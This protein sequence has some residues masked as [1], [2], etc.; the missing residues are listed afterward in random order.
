MPKGDCPT[1]FLLAGPQGI[2][3]RS[4]VLETVILPL[5]HGPNLLFFGFGNF[6]LTVLSMF[7]T[8]LTKLLQL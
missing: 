3:P 1:G 8:L 6:N 4:T 5:N 7:P 2:E